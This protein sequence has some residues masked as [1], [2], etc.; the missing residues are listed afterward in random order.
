M[1]AAKEQCEKLKKRVAQLEQ[2]HKESNE[3]YKFSTMKVAELEKQLKQHQADLHA[4]KKD[5]MTL[6]DENERLN[7]EMDILLTAPA[8]AEVQQTAKPLVTGMAPLNL[9]KTSDLE[10]VEDTTAMFTNRR[11]VDHGGA[12]FSGY[13]QPSDEFLQTP[14]RGSIILDDEKGEYAEPLLKT[15]TMAAPQHSSPQ[16]PSVAMHTTSKKLVA[17]KYVQTIYPMSEEKD[18]KDAG[19]PQCVIC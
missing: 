6:K 3:D 15:E 1:Y 16:L 12:Y 5:A 10:H 17:D 9:K 13:D 11:L 4:A 7:D 18:S 14:R 2:I 19:C 8:P